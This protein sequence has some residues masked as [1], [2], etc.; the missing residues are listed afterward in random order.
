M[1]ETSTEPSSIMCEDDDREYSIV[2]REKSKKT[3]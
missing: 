2:K 3:V 1:T